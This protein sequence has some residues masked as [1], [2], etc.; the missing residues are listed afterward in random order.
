MAG[1]CMRTANNDLVTSEWED[2]QYKFGNKTGKYATHEAELKQQKAMKA[3]VEDFVA[4]YNPLEHRTVEELDKM[5]EEDA[6]GDEDEDAIVRYREQRRQEMLE[7][8]RGQRHV[9]VRRIAKSEYIS[10][11]NR[12]G[13]GVWVVLLLIEE[14]HADCDALLRGCTEAAERNPR[15]KFLTIK[16][17][18]AI[19]NFPR[20][21]LPKVLLYFEEKMHRQVDGMMPWGSK[22]PSCEDIE[23]ALRRLGPLRGEKK[24]AASD[25][26]DEDEEEERERAP[27]G[28]PRRGGNRYSIM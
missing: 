10:E 12:A 21:E 6:L 25:D 19:E 27:V 24:A 22:T 20:A 16:S 28:V 17:T 1:N 8:Q 26:E 14:G 15:I 13:E 2:V 4:D 11:V 9:G 23:E 18:D 3:L 5:L 7:R